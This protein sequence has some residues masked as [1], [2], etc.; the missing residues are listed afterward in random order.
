M[1]V[2]ELIDEL[3][4]KIDSCELSK[5]A[6]VYFRDERG[7]VHDLNYEIRTDEEGDAELTEFN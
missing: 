3:K 7:Y 6:V 5:D 1:K 2:H 4:K